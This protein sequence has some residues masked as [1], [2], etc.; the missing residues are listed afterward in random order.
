M[1]PE[2]ELGE[3]TPTGV[4]SG[5][6]SESYGAPGAFDRDLS[7]AAEIANT[8]SG[9]AWMKVEF[10]KTY[11]IH[12]VRVHSNFYT[13]WFKPGGWCVESEAQFKVCVDNQ[14]NVDVS[15]YQGE[16]K[17]KS[18]GT[19][20]L[21]YGL[22]QSDQIYTLICNTEGDTVKLSKSKG[23]IIIQEVVVSGTGAVL[24]IIIFFKY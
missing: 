12:K 7:T 19:L 17:Q 5:N 3:I 4:T 11:F 8:G 1:E 14:N 15:V 10:Y 2:S 20:E 24:Q 23:T 22:K 21:T 18:C 13:N 6:S 16:A 9:V